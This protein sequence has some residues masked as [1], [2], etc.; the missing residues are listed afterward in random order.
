MCGLVKGGCGLLRGVCG[1]ADVSEV[2]SGRFRISTTLIFMRGG[3]GG[4]E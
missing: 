4:E 3:G 2:Y 1:L